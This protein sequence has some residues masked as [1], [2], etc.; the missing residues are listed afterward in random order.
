MR[1]R[2]LRLLL[3]GADDGRP[4]VLVDAMGLDDL[5][6][7]EARVGEVA[8]VFVV[9]DSAGDAADVLGD[10]GAG[11]VVHSGVGDDVGDGEG[12]AGLE[13]AGGFAQDLGF[14]G[15]EVDDAWR[16]CASSGSTSP[17]D[18]RNG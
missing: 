2:A 15:G 10:V 16:S 17:S 1:V 6:V 8:R 5:D 4:G 14:V 11:G 3:A 12:A 9:G 18:A 13:D 7:R